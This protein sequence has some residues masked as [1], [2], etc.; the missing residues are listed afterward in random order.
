[1]ILDDLPTPCLL[2]ERSRLESNLET[3]QARADEQG[4]RLR[5][6]IKTHKTVALARMQEGLGARGITAAK[7]GEA[8]RFVSDGFDDVCIAYPVVGDDKLRR[9]AELLSSARISFCVDTRESA[10][11]AS[12]FFAGRESVVD[13]LL[14]VDVGHHRCGVDPSDDRSVKLAREF[15]ALPGVR[16]KGILTHA[17]HVYHGPREG[18]SKE[19]AMRRVST[20]ERDTMLGFAERL[21]EAGVAEP[22]N[23]EI[24]VGSTPTARHFEN[25]ELGGFR[26]TEM[27]PGNYVFNDAMQVS[28]GSAD[29]ED[30]ALTVLTT[31]VSRHRNRSGRER[32][33]ADAGSKVVA[34]DKGPLT[35][36]YGQ[37]LY[38]A[39]RMQP[40]PHARIAGLSEEHSWIEV[41]G[42]STLAV[43]N[44]VRFVPNHACVCTNLLDVVYVVDGEEVIDTWPVDARGRVY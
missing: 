43:G 41:S 39:R 4:V 15:A 25:S 22:G 24:S 7:V 44:R 5:P 8:E 9:I 20:E 27:R 6:H 10:K 12:N 13:V 31:I 21:H 26:V 29:L 19:E 28:L 36:G 35:D 18:E 16:L 33:F 2:V 38:N 11:A 40:L 32:L 42:G 14:E 1:M 37:M 17:G 30:C 23:F 34:T 3:M